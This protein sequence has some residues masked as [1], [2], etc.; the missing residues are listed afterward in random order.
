MIRLSYESSDVAEHWQQAGDNKTSDRDFK[1]AVE[2]LTLAGYKPADLEAYILTGLPG[3]TMNEIEH[4]TQYVHK[5]GLQ[6]RLCQYS[7]IP[8]TPLFEL[9]CRQFGIDPNEP[10]LHNNSILPV[11]DNTVSYHTFQQFK[12]HIANLNHSLLSNPK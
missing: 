4:S 1:L 9:S 6:I 3:Q 5:L 12:T 7:P 2:C 11:L 8:G 10:L